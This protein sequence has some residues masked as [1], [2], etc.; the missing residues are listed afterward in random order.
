M[1]RVE[2]SD[3]VPHSVRGLHSITVYGPEAA[4]R[5]DDANDQCKNNAGS[6]AGGALVSIHSQE[7]QDNIKYRIG[8]ESVENSFAVYGRTSQNISRNFS[9]R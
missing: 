8:Q 3:F 1:G 9:H 2:Y 4:R 6:N 7:D 5:Y